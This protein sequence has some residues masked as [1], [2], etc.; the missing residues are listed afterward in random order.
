MAAKDQE[1]IEKYFYQPAKT[2]QVTGIEQTTF[3]PL[4]SE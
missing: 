3:M 2:A 1:T 4:T